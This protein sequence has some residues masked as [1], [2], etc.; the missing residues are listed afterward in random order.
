MLCWASLAVSIVPLFICL[1][2]VKFHSPDVR[3]FLL[4][5]K[6]EQ[7]SDASEDEDEKVSTG[8]RQLILLILLI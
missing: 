2:R 4:M 5:E 8:F 1:P 6:M 3:T 7:I